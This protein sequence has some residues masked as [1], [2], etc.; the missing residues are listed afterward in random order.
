MGTCTIP[1][2]PGWV[3]PKWAGCDKRWRNFVDFND[4]KDLTL[5]FKDK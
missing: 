1:D 2:Q 5:Q 4:Y 3:D